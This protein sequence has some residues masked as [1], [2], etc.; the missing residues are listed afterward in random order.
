MLHWRDNAMV[1]KA[2]SPAS[3]GFCAERTQKIVSTLQGHVDRQHLPGAV[4]MV[5]R[6]G[7]VLLYS[8]IGQQDPQSRMPMAHDAIFRIYSMTKP[9]ASLVA[10]MLME[11]GR[12]L[13]SH[14]V[15][16]YLPAFAGQR[17]YD[18]AIARGGPRRWW[19][20]YGDRW[21]VPVVT[22]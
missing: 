3:H 2:A 9:I 22:S 19:F 12:L 7:Q 16:H 5:V 20:D 13:L 1:L 21:V 8:A 18:E 11:E 14:P 17:V 15:S 4:A 6:H 10:M